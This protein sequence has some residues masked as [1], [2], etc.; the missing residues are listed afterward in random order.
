LTAIYSRVAD[1]ADIIE[2]RGGM[3]DYELAVLRKCIAD[4]IKLGAPHPMKQRFSTRGDALGITRRDQG[5]VTLAAFVMRYHE[6]WQP[7]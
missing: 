6:E 5:I 7:T 2:A 1:A 4:L 3:S